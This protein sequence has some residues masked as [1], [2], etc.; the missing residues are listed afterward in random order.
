[1]PSKESPN[2]EVQLLSYIAYQV[3]IRV[4][5][6][7]D[8]FVRFMLSLLK[9]IFLY[10]VCFNTMKYIKKALNLIRSCA[11]ILQCN[12]NYIIFTFLQVLAEYNF[13]SRAH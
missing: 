5:K 2:K 10:F 12:T 4:V 9:R 3:Y 6:P 1:M 8:L 7:Y 13:Y 11:I